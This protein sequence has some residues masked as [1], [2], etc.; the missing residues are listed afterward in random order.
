MAR[1]ADAEESLFTSTDSPG[2][3]MDAF[4]A[5]LNLNVYDWAICV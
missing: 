5:G 3:E 1:Q 2:E 4:G